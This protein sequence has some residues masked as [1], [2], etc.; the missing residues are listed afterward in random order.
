MPRTRGTLRIWVL[1]SVLLPLIVIPFLVFTA[2]CIWVFETGLLPEYDRKA[3]TAG[4]GVKRD[5]EYALDIGVPL[6]QLRGMDSFLDGVR[7]SSDT[8]GFLAITDSSNILLYNTSQSP[9]A[10]E[11]MIRRAQRRAIDGAAELRSAQMSEISNLV[12][13]VYGATT[14]E[15]LILEQGQV[16]ARIDDH[17]ITSLPI[18]SAGQTIARIHVGVDVA[19]LNR[20]VTDLVFDTVTVFLS[21]LVIA[22]E[23]LILILTVH[24]VRPLTIL[25]HLSQR[26][27]DRDLTSTLNVDSQGVVSR[28][29]EKVNVFIERSVA[30]IIA[31]RA[32]ASERAKEAIVAKDLLS[33]P[34]NYKLA[35]NG[36]VEQ[37]RLPALTYIRLPLFLFFLSEA[38]LRPILPAVIG[39]LDNS[40]AALSS[41]TVIGLPFSAFMLTS[42]LGVLIGSL[43]AERHGTRLIFLIGAILAAVSLFLQGF[44]TNVTEMLMVRAASGLGYGLVY[45][46][47]QVYVVHNS[48]QARRASGFSVFLSSVVAAEICGPA[49]GGIISDR[50]GT[51]ATFTI[52]GMIL[53]LATIIASRFLGGAQQW[54]GSVGQKARSGLSTFGKSCA[55]LSRNPRFFVLTLLFAVPSKLL[56]TGA[57]FFLIPLSATQLEATAAEIG[58]VLT[59]YGLAV[60]FVGPLCARLADRYRA[61]GFMVALGGFMSAIGLIYAGLDPSLFSLSVAV[62]GIGIGQAMSIPSQLTFTLE[63][64]EAEVVEAGAG[65][66]LGVFR[67][68][69]R[70]GSLAGPIVATLLLGWFAST[71][72]ALLG[73]GI[74]AVLAATFASAIFL[75]FGAKEEERQIEDLYERAGG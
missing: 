57:I 18:T 25:K 5:V 52:G 72:M 29:A 23:F 74:Y 61:F 40:F 59:V 13:R 4:T 12:S 65:P 42:I 7:E 33:L 55:M 1:I 20:V 41:E 16:S 50:L 17:Y 28:V 38:L 30:R 60:L 56:L 36:T 32:S 3:W 15:Q 2:F 54:A 39:D 21:A 24:L 58:R 68:V 37:T 35:E 22:I 19:V 64:A 71:D 53:V 6:R 48:D 26:L 67:L 63:V 49:I 11:S 44:V 14:G 34:T 66:V 62:F 10:L 8:I 75:T 73:L 43:S 27:R 31:L 45:A 46:A 69:E 9:P 51:I 70:I 47:A